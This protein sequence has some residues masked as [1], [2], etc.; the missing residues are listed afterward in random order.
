[1]L[2]GLIADNRKHGW[3]V[4]AAGA[5]SARVRADRMAERVEPEWDSG[6]MQTLAG[7]HR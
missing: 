5:D 7:K 6:E 3:T 1:M 2:S 4:D